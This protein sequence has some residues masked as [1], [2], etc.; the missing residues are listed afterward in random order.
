MS[1]KRSHIGV[2]REAMFQF[3]ASHNCDFELTSQEFGVS[4][5]TCR[6]YASRDGWTPR[7]EKMREQ[8]NTKALAALQ[9]SLDEVALKHV[10][11]A[12]AMLA[13]GLAALSEMP[14]PESAD[15]ARKLIES[16]VKIERE[17]RGMAEKKTAHSLEIVLK[18]K[19]SQLLDTNP[20]P[21]RLLVEPAEDESEE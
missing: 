20:G 7:L 3:W 9:G 13:L 4:L 6:T 18:D 8:A 1:E 17:A 14:K 11:A 21:R 2:D 16:A 19:F 10:E 5:S 12:Q 15:E